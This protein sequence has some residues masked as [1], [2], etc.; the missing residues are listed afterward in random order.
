MNQKT[1]SEK[2]INNI[3]LALGLIS[4]KNK[5][6][7]HEPDFS[8]SNAKKYLNSCIDSGWV[9][10]AGDWVNKFENKISE[11]TG[12]KYAVAVSNG[13]VALRLS[14]HC[15]GVN[16]TDEVLLPPMSF[17]ATANAVAHL[18]ANP[19]FIDI[20][21]DSLGMCPI[22]LEK[23]LSDI[24]IIKDGNV[25]NKETGNFI[26]AVL[27]VHVFGLAPKI[28]E[29]KSICNTWNLPIIEDA[30]E[31]LGSYITFKNNLIHA[32]CIGDIGTISFNGNKIITTGGGG[33]IITNDKKTADLARHLSTTAKINHPY[34]FFHDQIGWNDRLPNLNAALGVS[35]LELLENI[36][37]KKHKLHKVYKNI[38]KSSD[39]FE[40]ISQPKN[41]KSNYWLITL[42]LKFDNPLKIRNEI[43]INAN[44]NGILLR[45]SWNLI[46]D[47]PMYL[48][49]QKGDLKVAVDQSNRL[50]NLPSSPKLLK[51]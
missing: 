42:R 36:L 51:N 37:E 40:I 3:K 50:I 32:G 1:E 44:M 17:I 23:R 14:L 38:F 6:N 45:P 2:V 41:T 10:S 47:L 9:S 30:A 7:L 49:C 19:H 48:D 21:A 35:Q 34:E 11:I 8:N 18:G 39:N 12:S 26:K 13:T 46:S 16:R 27:P 25:I 4:N 24:A 43:L 20:E 29:I 15:A 5:V 33:V 31:A 28:N 22:A